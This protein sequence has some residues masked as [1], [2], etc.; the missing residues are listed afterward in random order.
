MYSWSAVAEQAE[1]QTAHTAQAVVARDKYCKQRS[2]FQLQ[3]IQ[4]RSA[5][6]VHHL[7][8]K[9]AV[10]ALVPVLQH[11]LLR[12]V[13]VAVQAHRAIELQL[14]KVEAAAVALD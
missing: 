4:S 6:A 13:A 3:H 9:Q 5:Q 1:V 11:S 2:I 10:T 14:A 8:T 12:L 7:L